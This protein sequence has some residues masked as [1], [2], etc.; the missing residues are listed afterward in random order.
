MDEFKRDVS[1][2]YD[3]IS[4]ALHDPANIGDKNLD[5]ELLADAVAQKIETARE[6][7]QENPRKMP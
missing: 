7:F 3:D 5:Y 4:E 1:F 2:D 6:P